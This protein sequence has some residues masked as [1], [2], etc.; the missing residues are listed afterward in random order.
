[1]WRRRR[2]TKPDI[3][4][5]F[6]KADVRRVEGIEWALTRFEKVEKALLRALE[7]AREAAAGG[8]LWLHFLFLPNSRRRVRP[9]ESAV[10]LFWHALRLRSALR[11]LAR[12]GF[13]EGEIRFVEEPLAIPHSL[14]ILRR[15]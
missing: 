8:A 4:P 7:V 11:E 1:M 6:W 3:I 14:R 9:N 12:L 5:N 10:S 13:R 2:Q 15:K